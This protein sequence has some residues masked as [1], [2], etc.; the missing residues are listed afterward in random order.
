MLCGLSVQ[1][2]TRQNHGKHRQEGHQ[3]VGLRQHGKLQ[4]ML[5]TLKSSG[6][7]AAVGER[8]LAS[9]HCPRLQITH[10]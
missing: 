1:H 3:E 10:D 8:V 5:Q 2:T 4:R 7:Y 6:N 9:S